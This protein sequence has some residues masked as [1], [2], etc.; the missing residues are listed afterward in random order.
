FSLAGSVV[1]DA[2]K[3]K[4]LC[5][6]GEFAWGGVASTGFWVDRAEGIVAI[7]MTQLTPSSSY[8]IRRE[9]RSLVYQAITE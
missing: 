9:L 2:A 4:A 7:F 5:S 8:P 1:I 3:A 6:E